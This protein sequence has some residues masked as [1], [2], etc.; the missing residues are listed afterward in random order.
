M[1]VLE[2]EQ[3]INLLVKEIKE[4]FQIIFMKQYKNSK[5]K[6]LYIQYE[7]DEEVLIAFNDEIE[8]EWHTLQYIID[9]LRMYNINKC[10]SRKNNNN[11]I[12]IIYK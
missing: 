3:F 1:T 4:E 10:I 7:T 9:V 8:G 2:K 5:V 6:K 11:I 12:T